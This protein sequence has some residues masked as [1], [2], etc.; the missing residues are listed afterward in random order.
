M[1]YGW[2]G[3]LCRL[4]PLEPARHAEAVVRW[5]NTPEVTQWLLSGDTPTTMSGEATWFEEVARDTTR[6]IFAIE[7]FTG[8][9]LGNIGLHDVNYRDGTAVIGLLIGDTRNWGRGYGTD[10]LRTLTRYAIGVAGL[11]LLMAEVMV[12][13]ERSERLFGKVGYRECGVIPQRYWK[14][15]A[16]RDVKLFCFLREQLEDDSV[17]KA[18]GLVE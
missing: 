5:L 13:N 15:G 18:W 12:G 1:A 9:H 17:L 14:R 6:I 7:T 11:R 3:E 8:D 10:A 16:Y 2:A 4:V